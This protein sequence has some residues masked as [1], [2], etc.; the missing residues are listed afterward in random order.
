MLTGKHLVAGDW[1]A[2]ETTFTSEPAHGPAHDFA[3]GTPDLVDRAAKAAEEAFWSYGYSTREERAAFLNAIADE[4]EAR[5]AAITEIGTQ[6][7]GLPA[8]RLNGE[9]GRTTGQLR[10]FA[11]H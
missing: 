5:G 8:A 7:T 9:R 3:V 1:V 6:E 2:T 10:L 11:S 4:I